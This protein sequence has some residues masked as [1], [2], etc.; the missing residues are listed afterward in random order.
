MKYI[1]IHMTEEDFVREKINIIKSE[2]ASNNK[3][4]NCEPVF[5]AIKIRKLALI[6]FFSESCTLVLPSNV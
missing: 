2:D 5:A 6:Q 4:V 1:A 3:R